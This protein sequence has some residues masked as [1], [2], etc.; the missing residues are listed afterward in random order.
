MKKSIC[1]L[2]ASLLLFLCGCSASQNNL[3]TVTFYYCTERMQY[4]S[5]RSA[6]YPEQRKV[7]YDDPIEL[8]NLY[9]KG[10]VDEHLDT[11]FPAGV[12][13][14]DFVQED[15]TARIKLSNQVGRLS[16]IDLSVACAT[17]TMTVADLFGTDTIVISGS[18][19]LLDGKKAIT[20]SVSDI[21]WSDTTPA[22][23]EK[24]NID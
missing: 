22:N 10:P 4:K 21:I 3:D 2:M 16:G 1:I 13:V 20:L 5:E 9:L 19:V 18:D 15:S 12:T 7:A 11:P 24:S 14:V 23:T 6:F 17:L 8:L